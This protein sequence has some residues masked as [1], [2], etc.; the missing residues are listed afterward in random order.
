[1]VTKMQLNQPL[2]QPSMSSGFWGG[3]K[4]MHCGSFSPHWKVELAPEREAEFCRFLGFS[5]CRQ[6]LSFLPLLF[7]T[8]ALLF[9]KRR[10]LAT[11]AIIA[12]LS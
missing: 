3:N 12:L 5:P 8:F 1:M 11:T 2:K 6:S 4:N 7:H 10:K 9:L